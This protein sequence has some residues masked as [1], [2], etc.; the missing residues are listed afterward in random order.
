MK[1]RLPLGLVIVAIFQFLAPMLLPP[2]VLA[3]VNPLAWVLVLVVFGLLGFNLLR[4]RPWSRV[5]TIFVQGF[6][7][8][9][10]LLVGVGH[11]LVGGKA[12]GPVDF[13]LLAT[14]ALSI[15]LSGIILY[16]VDLPDVQILMQ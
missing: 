2:A 14:Y 12:G 1:T 5:A 16:Y 3:G 4:R 6:S 8:I 13:W 11:G 9:V 10:H 7:I 15:A